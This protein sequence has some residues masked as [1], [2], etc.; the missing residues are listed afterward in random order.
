MAAF[1]TT[2]FNP[3]IRMPYQQLLTAGKP[4]KLARVACIRKLITILNAMIMKGEKWDNS[5]K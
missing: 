4:K 5:F 1:V 3:A 2:Q